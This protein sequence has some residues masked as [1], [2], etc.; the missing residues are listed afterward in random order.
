MSR[1]W[2]GCS[3]W[4]YD[5]WVGPFYPR[6]TPPSEFLE[7]YARVFRTVEVDSSFYRAPSP[8]LVRR[9]ADRTPPGFR[10]SLKIPKDVTHG[11]GAADSPGVLQTFLASLAP[12]E[13]AGKLGPV[14]L[15]FPASFRRG[16]QA[17]Q[18]A[19]LLERVPRRYAL[20]VELRHDSWWVEATRRELESRGA[21]LVW[22]VLPGTQPPAWRT[23]DVVYA[24]FIGDR[25]L[26][27]FDRVQRE[28]RPALEAMR[29]RFDE[30]GLTASAVY[31]YSNN[32]FMGFAPATVRE[33]AEVLHEPLR[34]CPGRP[35]GKGRRRWT[36]CRTAADPVASRRRP[37]GTSPRRLPFG[38]SYYSPRRGPNRRRWERL[39][40]CASPRRSSRI[41]AWGPPVSTSRRGNGSRSASGTS[42]RYAA[43]RPP[44]QSSSR[45]QPDDE[46]KG[47]VRIEAVVRRNAGVSIGDRVAVHRADCPNADAITIAPIYAGSA[48]MDLGPGLESFVAKALSRRPFVRGDVFVIP[49]VFLMGGSLPFMV[50][51]TQPKG[52]VQ[53]APS[54]QITIREDTVSEAEV[55][56]PR[57]SYEDIGGLQEKLGRVREMIELPLKHPELF[58]RLAITPPKGVLLYGPPVPGRP[59]SP[60][61]SRTRPGPTSS[62]SRDPRSSR[63]T[64]GRARR[65]YGRS[66]RTPRRTRPA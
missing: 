42:S 12:L 41:S 23:A 48:R 38:P 61:P 4:A 14:V 49:G 9:W 40:P 31:A 19:S 22:S 8:F 53:V 55:A 20:A 39:P 64:T 26:D 17:A 2:L 30:E 27:R 33:L 5:D 37:T 45:A 7:R 52:T 46:G 35:A 51:S 59:S 47:L 66:S 29:G 28:G 58:D 16:R 63:S 13:Q 36:T 10:F 18:F 24:R 43:G 1:Y 65:S 25:A 54:T 34:G 50:V 11:P 60:R 56:A 6:G 3:G 44:R 62:G 32:H 21:A 15:Q 57:V